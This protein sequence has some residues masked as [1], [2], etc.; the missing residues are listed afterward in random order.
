MPLNTKTDIITHSQSAK[1]EWN[2]MYKKYR[3]IKYKWR[4]SGQII[5]NAMR[6]VQ[7]V[8]VM[9]G[10]NLLA[11]CSFLWLSMIF[12]AFGRATDE[13]H[14]VIVTS[15]LL[16][17][18]QSMHHCIAAKWMCLCVF[19][20]FFF[21]RFYSL[22]MEAILCAPHLFGVIILYIRINLKWKNCDLSTVDLYMCSL[23]IVRCTRC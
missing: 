5:L 12:Y 20:G 15:W 16:C 13:A 18:I 21:L 2:I 23:Y 14:F 22:L 8:V 19:F 11:D 1:I 7:C 6:W 10:N 9:A 17:C 3:L 4:K